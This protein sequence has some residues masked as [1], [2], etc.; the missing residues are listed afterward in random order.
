MKINDNWKP[1]YITPTYKF[2]GVIYKALHLAEM[3]YEAKGGESRLCRIPI[4]GIPNPLTLIITVQFQSEE[5]SS[6]DVFQ[7]IEN[8]K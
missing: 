3:Q 6:F 4:K 8:K 5:Q 7:E 2:W 1:L